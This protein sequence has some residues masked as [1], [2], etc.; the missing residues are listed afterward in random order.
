MFSPAFLSL[1]A[2][3]IAIV[4]SMTSRINVGLLSL[5]FAWLVGSFSAHLNAEGIAKGFPSSLFLTLVGI[6]TLFAAA[7]SNGTLEQL[8]RRAASLARGSAR[9]L[10]LIF[11]GLSAIL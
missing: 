11:F 5:A 2:L 4:L 10:P 9:A 6:T 1:I 3:L 7:E 8:A